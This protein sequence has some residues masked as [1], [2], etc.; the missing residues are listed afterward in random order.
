MRAATTNDR[1][2]SSNDAIDHGSGVPSRT[3]SAGTRS[4]VSMRS[5]NVT[6]EPIAGL[7]ERIRHMLEAALT[8]PVQEPVR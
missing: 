6:H 4:L 8:T 3:T 5:V 2:A 1:G 7:G